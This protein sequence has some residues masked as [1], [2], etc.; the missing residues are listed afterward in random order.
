[1]QQSVS[2]TRN[3]AAQRLLALR[4]M[5][6]RAASG[7]RADNDV[8]LYSL[9]PP[10]EDPQDRLAQAQ[11]FAVAHHLL[12]RERHFDIGEAGA[13]APRWA[14]ARAKS[15]LLSGRAGGLVVST[16][17][18]VST[19]DEV[20]ETELRWFHHHCLSLWLVR[21]ESGVLL[22]TAPPAQDMR[23]NAD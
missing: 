20:Y 4:E 6:N 22:P 2:R 14:W 12:V 18:D 23:R 9:C 3:A 13:A 10:G 19:L 17:A 5:G 11:G 16:R 15:A 21:P 8:V 7:K 1:M